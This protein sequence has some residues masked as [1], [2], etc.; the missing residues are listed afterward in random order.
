HAATAPE[1][2]H[3]AA[4]GEEID[5]LLRLLTD[6]AFVAAEA[7][8]EV[9]RVQVRGDLVLAEL[10]PLALETREALAEARRKTSLDVVRRGEEAVNA[11]LPIDDRG[12]PPAHEADDD[13][14]RER[15]DRTDEPLS[16]RRVVHDLV[17]ERLGEGADGVLHVVGEQTPAAGQLGAEQRLHLG[18][19]DAALALAPDALADLGEDRVEVDPR[20]AHA[21]HLSVFTARSRSRR[22]MMRSTM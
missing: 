22:S 12:H 18:T 20:V 2:E 10:L 7:R 4:A 13:P 16:A 21:R 6:D 15:D 11:L 3:A 19:V 5:E 8:L 1:I 14:A 9:H 17:V